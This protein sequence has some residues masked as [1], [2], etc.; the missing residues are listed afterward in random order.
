MSAYTGRERREVPSR[1]T[2]LTS[3]R[4]LLA[5]FLVVSA[6]VAVAGRVYFE[7]QRATLM[8]RIDSELTQ[9]RDLKSAQ[10]AQWRSMLVDD[11]TVVASDPTVSDEIDDWLIARQGGSA[12]ARI[13]AWLENLAGARG[14]VAACLISTDGSRW[15]AS[16]GRGAPTRQEM[17]EA[18]AAQGSSEPTVTELYLDEV[19]GEPRLDVVAPLTGNTG[20][21][22]AAIIL[23]R[24]PTEYL[25]PLIQ[26]WPLPSASSETLLLRRAGDS[27]LYLNDLKFRADAALRFSLPLTQQDL[28]A[29]KAISGPARVVEGIDYRGI[30]VVGAVAPVQGTDWF[31]VAKI[32]QSEAYAPIQNV[33]VSTLLASGLIVL[34]FAF[35]FLIVWRQNAIAFLRQRLESERTER[36]LSQQYEYLTRYANDAVI[37]ADHELRI[38]QANE[39]TEH[40]YGYSREEL[41]AMSLGEL[42]APGTP[43]AQTLD[44]LLLKSSGVSIFQTPHATKDGRRLEVEA[45]ARAIESEGATQ[46]IIVIRDVTERLR[47]EAAIRQSEERLRRAVQ[48]A[49]MP[50]M[51]HAEDGEV[52]QINST[53]QELSGYS[54]EDIPTTADWTE[55][56]YGTHAELVRADIEALYGMQV[57]R[58]EGEYTIRTADGS[59]R[60]WD[61]GSAP[62]GRLPDGRRIVMSTARDITER[63]RAEDELHARTEELARSNA[64]L[65]KFAYVASHDLQEP[66]RMVASYTQ[67]LQQRYA[68][69]LD[70]DADEFIGYAVDGAARMRTLINDLLAYSRVGT[71]GSTF[72]ETNLETVLTDV[73]SSLGPSL[74]D[75][76]AMVTRDPMP[77]VRCD[78][79]QLGQV[80]QNLISNAAKFHGAEPPLIRVGARREGAE[81]VFSVSDNGIGIDP[82]Y[83]DRIFVIFQRLESR[84]KY[85]GTGIGLAVCKRILLRHGGRI[86]VESQPGAG[87]TFHFTLPA[88]IEEPA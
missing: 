1:R 46:Y 54:P 56:A 39:R 81:W 34:A 38:V 76:A 82:Q 12:E 48:D 30:A 72:V 85:P 75:V 83:F 88:D 50:I 74:Q 71:Q 5:V 45:S 20:T 73:L 25:Y 84:A 19:T 79:T 23:E 3:G 36:V 26:T 52:I 86:W 35:G 32:D 68:G 59:M 16:G 7:S 2:G 77:T 63:K 27:I 70:S 8:A 66:L 21:A 47:G 44:S 78:P 24:D 87:S 29:V 49:P 80:F 28:L 9:I 61:F 14:Y 22:R 55:K 69:R 67:L 58:D 11:G 4:T 33:F 53:W 42:S 43:E 6:I 64:E 41:L 51:I 13:L 17:A 40:M 18:S 62:L 10:I 37:L 60:V 15:A 65:E 31:I 57:R